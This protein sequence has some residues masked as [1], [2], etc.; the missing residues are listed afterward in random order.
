MI[1]VLIVDDSKFMR[2]AI[3]KILLQEGLEVIGEAEEDSEAVTKYKELKPDLVTM[4]II[5]PIE[6]GLEAVKSICEYDPQARIIMVSAMGQES[7]VEESLK[8]GAKG[9]VIKPIKK[10]NLMEAIYA[11]IEN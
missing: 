7:V 4:D 1:S 10:E 6:S 2:M 3:K 9:F 5:M 11:C 8:L